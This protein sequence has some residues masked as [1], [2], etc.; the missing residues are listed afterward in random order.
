MQGRGASAGLEFHFPGWTADVGGGGP[1]GAYSTQDGSFRRVDD[2]RRDLDDLQ[3]EQAFDGEAVLPEAASPSAA[4]RRAETASPDSPSA[5]RPKT[6]LWEGEEGECSSSDH[7]ASLGALSDDLVMKILLLVDPRGVVSVSAASQRLHRLA[8][9]EEVW[10]GLWKRLGGRHRWES[11]AERCST[12]KERAAGLPAGVFEAL[13]PILPVPSEL[14]DPPSGYPQD[15]AT[16]DSWPTGKAIRIPKV[17]YSSASAE[18]LEFALTVLSSATI[19]SHTSAVAWKR[20]SNDSPTERRMPGH[21]TGAE[22]CG[23]VSPLARM[24]LPP[25]SCSRAAC[26]SGE[27]RLPEVQQFDDQHLR[28]DQVLR[29]KIHCHPGQFWYLYKSMTCLGRAADSFIGGLVATFYQ[30]SIQLY[31]LLPPGDNFTATVAIASQHLLQL[32]KYDWSKTY[33]G[34]CAICTAAADLIRLEVACKTGSQGVGSELWQRLPAGSPQDNAAVEHCVGEQADWDA[35]SESTVQS[36][37]CSSCPCPIDTCGLEHDTSVQAASGCVEFDGCIWMHVLEA[38]AVYQLW[39]RV[40]VQ[41][42]TLLADCVSAERT[43]EGMTFGGPKTPTIFSMGKAIFRSQVLLAHGLRSQLQ[44]SAELIQER[45][46]AYP[47][48]ALSMSRFLEDMDVSDDLTLPEQARTQ[49]KLWRCFGTK[50]GFRDR[51]SRVTV[52]EGGMGRS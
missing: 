3:E 51:E 29:P 5:K 1:A 8:M 7:V 30:A 22:E 36:S 31:A 49:E 14:T 47:S 33:D 19:G 17:D 26:G 32:T 20:A 50:S 18:Q 41:Q 2:W 52:L 40:V 34:L 16:S 45:R 48:L 6:Q 24:I 44:T 9:S 42:C 21:P 25:F 23:L 10:S 37:G 11:G 43:A 15:A 4:S 35:C 12:L 27:H 46:D 28:K 38:W 13:Q 39:L